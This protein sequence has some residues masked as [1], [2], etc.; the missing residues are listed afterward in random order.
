MPPPRIR[1]T[2]SVPADDEIPLSSEST[3][4]YDLRDALNP[5]GAAFLSAAPVFR[6]L[7]AAVRPATLSE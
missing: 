1:N 7:G 2:L 6:P 4:E 3:N 5:N